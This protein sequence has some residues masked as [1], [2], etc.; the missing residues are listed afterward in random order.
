MIGGLPP[1]YSE[2][3]NEMYQRVSRSTMPIRGL[4]RLTTSFVPA[5]ILSDPLKF[6]D[7]FS[8]EAR[9]ILTGL[10]TRDPAQRLGANGAED[11]KRHLFFATHIDFKKLMA[12][13][14]KPPFKPNVESA[15]DTSNV[16]HGMRLCLVECVSDSGVICFPLCSSTLNSPARHLPTRSLKAV[17]SRKV[18][19][20]LS[21][22]S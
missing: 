19:K 7:E 11:I 6:G 21:R 12:K 14:Y 15:A 9:S 10:L 2:N 1:F 22:D 20:Q 4:P 16:S 3:T 8:S 13:A 18:N 17:D 5:Q